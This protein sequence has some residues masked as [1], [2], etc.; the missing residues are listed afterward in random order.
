MCAA[1]TTNESVFPKYLPTF[2]ITACLFQ[3]V[4][5]RLFHA[6]PPRAVSSELHVVCLCRRIGLQSMQRGRVFLISTICIK[7]S[8][9]SSCMLTVTDSFSFATMKSGPRFRSRSNNKCIVCSSPHGAITLGAH[10]STN[11]AVPSWPQPYLALFTC[12]IGE[13]LNE[14]LYFMRFNLTHSN[15]DLETALTQK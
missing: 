2:Q 10:F 14:L 7:K 4:Q 15:F 8:S 5:V 12:C 11:I 13:H 1:V 3:R 9:S 6:R